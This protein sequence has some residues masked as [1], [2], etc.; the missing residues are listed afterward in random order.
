MNILYLTNHFN[1]G[2]ISSYVLSLARG[3][4]ERGHGVYVASSS[5]ELFERLNEEGIPFLRIPINTK[6]E[7]NIPK[8]SASLFKSLR[9]VKEKEIDIIH[10]NTRV[11]SVLGFS[12][13]IFPAGRTYL[14]DTDFSGPG[15]PAGYS[16]AGA[17]R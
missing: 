17:G 10:S 9:Y 14:P 11:T 16:P 7:A 3:M 5:G 13:G 12:W 8:I 15:S 6:S 4:K 2:G 1:I